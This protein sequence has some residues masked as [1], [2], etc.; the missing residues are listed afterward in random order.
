[1]TVHSNWRADAACRD[2]DSDLFFPVGTTGPALRW[3]VGRHYSGRAARH[4]APRLK[5]DN[6]PGM[7][8]ATVN[9]EQSAENMEYVRR[10]L[11]QKQPG[12]SAALE[13]TVDLVGRGLESPTCCATSA[14]PS[15]D[16]PTN[17]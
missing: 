12:F 3:C 2:A 7:T 9:S 14:L 1:M 8:M 16:P 10:L 15:L 17:S 11:K 13:S 4:P 6:Q 5:G